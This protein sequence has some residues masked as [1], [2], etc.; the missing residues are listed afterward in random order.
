MVLARRVE[1]GQ[2][3]VVGLCHWLADG[4]AQWRWQPAVLKSVPSPC[5]DSCAAQLQVAPGVGQVLDGLPFLLV[6]VGLVEISPPRFD[7]QRWPLHVLPPTAVSRICSTRGRYG[8]SARS[9]V[10]HTDVM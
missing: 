2:A 8:G 1:E 7:G 4:S 3:A 9:E 6:F 5:P 10:S